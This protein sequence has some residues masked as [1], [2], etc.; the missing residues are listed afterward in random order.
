MTGL[1][2]GGRTAGHGHDGNEDRA[3]GAGVSR[4]RATWSSRL[5]AV[6][7]ALAALGIQP[8]L[9]SAGEYQI[10]FCK[11]WT[12]DE[13]A[14]QLA[15][16]HTYSGGVNNECHR[17]GPGGG[18][19][20]LVTGATMQFD[21]ASGIAL[22]VP[23]DRAG[24]TISRVWTEYSSPATGGS[25]AFVRLLAGGTLLDN[26]AT[27]Q[28]RSDDRPLPA[29]ARDLE[30][31]MF[32]STSGSTYCYFPSPSDVHHVYKARLFLSESVDPSLAVTGGSLLGAGPKAGPR[33][34][35][36]DAVDAD[37]GMSA[38][39][40]RL[41]ATVVADVAYSCAFDDWSACRRDRRG[42]V[43][44]VD[45]RKVLD[46]MHPL[47]VTV[48]DAAGNQTRKEL[49]DVTIANIPSAAVTQRE[50]STGRQALIRLGRSRLTVSS[51]RPAIIR[52]RLV[53]DDDRPIADA[54]IQ[55]DERVYI[56]KTGLIG[57]AW[58]RLGHVVSDAAGAFVAEIPAGASRA[59]R[60]SY[61]SGGTGDTA[62]ARVS[63]RAGVTVRASRRVV[64][65]GSS[66][67]FTGRVAGT[68]PRAGVI[69]TLQAYVPGDGWRASDSRPKVARARTDG[70]F[71]V[72][73]WFRNTPR[74]T[75]YRFRVLVN[76]DSAFA[77]TRSTSRAIAV[78]VLPRWRSVR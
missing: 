17:G 25:L 12:N 58:T 15:F 59:L 56:P 8:A 64:R 70:R 19:H 46:G 53:D 35:A 32:C 42:Q 5:A 68:I 10:D 55:V 7:V 76:E 13:P 39:T 44:D 49:G 36:L 41:G 77:Y 65:N 71:R 33:T 69:V 18:L 6:V 9:A 78:T 37:S 51:G 24:I 34:V 29:G 57:P 14:A 3:S 48:R 31:S 54:T 4:W 22:Q 11:G 1:T 72:S 63:V 66:V 26:L 67:R 45:T 27:P 23:S 47:S 74:R 21:S 52:G 30:W 38:V 40:V 75:R 50:Q 2:A 60:F 43:I 28:V 16:T 20:A 62:E 73:Y 61:G